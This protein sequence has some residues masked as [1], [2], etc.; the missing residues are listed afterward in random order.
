MPGDGKQLEALVA[1]VEKTLLPQGFE[2]KNNERVYNDE[3]VPSAYRARSS[4]PSSF[5]NSI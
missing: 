2:V 4:T 3:G 1:F 5:K